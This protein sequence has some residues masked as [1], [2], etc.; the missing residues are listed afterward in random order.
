MRF[1]NR[2]WLFVFA[3]VMLLPVTAWAKD[4]E[5]TRGRIDVKNY[6]VDAKFDAAS[7]QLEAKVKMQVVARESAISDLDLNFNGNLT[8]TRVVDS[9]NRTLRYSQDVDASK[10]R[11]ELTNPLDKSQEESI[12]IEYH[13]VLER[14]D[15]SPV[16]DVLL[17]KVGDSS[18]YFLARSYWLP[19]NGYNF[20]RASIQLNMTVPSGLTAVSQGRLRGVD[21]GSAEDVYHWQTDAQDFPLTV[22]V[23]KYVETKVPT[24]SI[25]VVM[26]L[27]AS[28]AGLAK[29]YGE[30]AGKIIDFY[31]RKFSLFPFAGLTI[32]EIDDTTLGGYAAPGLVLLS[33][34]GLT[35]KVNYRLLAHEIAQQWWGLRMSPKFKSDDWLREGFAAYSAAL[36]IEDY[37]GTGAYEDEMKDIGVRA[38]THEDAGSI[39]NAS[40]LTEETNEYRSVVEY[41]GAFVLHMLRSVV[42]DDK[43]FKI[44]QTVATKYAYQP[45]TTADFKSVAEQVTAQDL[46]Y[47]FAE[48]VLS[49]GAPDFR[50][51]YTVYRT[52]KG[53]RV[54]GHVEQDM[55]TLRM[56]VEVKVETQGK[57]ESKT[58]EVIGTS[59]DFEISTFG[60]P[61]RIELD[62]NHRLLRYDDKIKILV[63]IQRG[64]DLFDQGEYVEAIEAYRKALDLDKHN[65]L[66]QYRIAEAFFAQHNYNSA[67]N[68]YREAL[69]GDLEP[70][71]IEVF[72]HLQLGKVYDALGQRERA[73][74]EYRRAID[75]ND[76]TQGAVDEARKYQA[77]PYKEPKTDFR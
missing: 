38:L 75:S 53:F 60:Q 24:E 22:A 17:A 7:H 64:K 36:F 41:K 67:A 27:N 9:R 5:D 76:N 49:T 47:F 10:L 18:G 11:V 63:A 57:P 74:A 26:Y 30:M 46:T 42:G 43:F 2:Q 15:R 71:W 72:C 19:M 65:S 51:K 55:D 32:A 35:A 59:S 4:P 44:I 40:R 23:G 13:G 28:E 25:P 52:Q 69:N 14:A 8:P 62:P 45:V 16:E 48:W 66:A 77:S 50:L 58:V 12:T 21:K 61:V 3:A 34:R 70:K 56:P 73:L 6:V 31:T 1:K 68:A 20:N 37:A 54:Q 33:H 29:S 39:S